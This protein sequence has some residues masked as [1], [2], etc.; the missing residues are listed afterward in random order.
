MISF[1]TSKTISMSLSKLRKGTI[2]SN[3]RSCMGQTKGRLQDEVVCGFEAV[4]LSAVN[5]AVDRVAGV[6]VDIPYFVQARLECLDTT[7]KD[8]VGNASQQEGIAMAAGGAAGLAV[9]AVGAGLGALGAGGALWIFGKYASHNHHVLGDFLLEKFGSKNVLWGSAWPPQPVPEVAQRLAGDRAAE[10]TRDVS[11]CMLNLQKETELLSYHYSRDL[12]WSRLQ[13]ELEGAIYDSG[14]SA[15]Q[16]EGRTLPPV[17]PPYRGTLKQNGAHSGWDPLQPSK[18][19]S[20]GRREEFDAALS[21]RLLAQRKLKGKEITTAENRLLALSR[22]DLARL[23]ADIARKRI[24]EEKKQE[25]AAEALR[26]EK[27]G[28][29]HRSIMQVLDLSVQVLNLKP[30][31]KRLLAVAVSIYG[32]TSGVRPLTP[33]GLLALAQHFAP[34]ELRSILGTV[35]SVRAIQQ[36]LQ[37][38][39]NPVT[40]CTVLNAEAAN[41]M[42]LVVSAIPGLP[43]QVQQFFSA[44][45]SFNKLVQLLSMA[46]TPSL[47]LAL[48]LVGLLSQIINLGGSCGAGR[49]KGGNSDCGRGRGR[50]SSNRGDREQ[51]R[52]AGGPNPPND[53]GAPPRDWA[54]GAGPG[55]YYRD[56]TARIAMAQPAGTAIADLGPN[57]PMRLAQTI[58]AQLGRMDDM[59]RRFAAYADWPAAQDQGA[60]SSAAQGNVLDMALHDATPI[61]GQLLPMRKPPLRPVTKLRLEM[62]GVTLSDHVQKACMSERALLADPVLEVQFWWK[63]TEKRLVTFEMSSEEHLPNG[64]P[65]DLLVPE[66]PPPPQERVRRKEPLPPPRPSSGGGGGRRRGC[67]VQ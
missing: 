4:A 57:S 22:A 48:A 55:R 24:M 27:V 61:G 14:P 60:A 49:G 34:A 44:V 30:K 15:F 41:L 63:F 64:P 31:H 43:P 21:D 25:Q 2:P 23:K 39:S 59:A 37:V 8:M 51:G 42:S 28:E 29:I 58:R 5:Y 32:H 3:F 45:A 62:K 38:L 52:F 50:G 1:S 26:K 11:R 6:M 16:L 46:C 56:P 20:F 13:R 36:S 54:A 47:Q 40:P 9:G 19:R 65:P 17:V 35:Q 10:L 67:E 33:D 12:Q 18:L 53:P 7:N 66:E